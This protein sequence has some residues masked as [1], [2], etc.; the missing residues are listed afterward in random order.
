M[1]IPTIELATAIHP[2]LRAL[3]WPDGFAVY[4]RGV[5]TDKDGTPNAQTVECARGTPCVDI[6]VGER[7]P[8]GHGSILRAHPLTLR[9]VTHQPHDQFQE[10][11]YTAGDVLAGWICSRPTLS[12]LTGIVCDSIFFSENPT[13]GNFGEN[14]VGQYIEW[15]ATINTRV[16]A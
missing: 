3:T 2:A 9:V 7:L 13:M 5:K 14:S 12:G 6:I 8:S 11:M 15:T 4:A 16:T 1:S 10:S